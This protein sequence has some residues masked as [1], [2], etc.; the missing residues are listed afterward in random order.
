MT[1]DAVVVGG[2]ILGCSTAWHLAR[3]GVRVAVIEREGAVGQGSTAR[4]TAIIRQRY[5]HPA[6]MALALE[7]LRTWERWPELVPPDADG[8]RAALRQVGVLFLLPAGEPTTR[9]LQDA[10][11]GVGIKADLLDR[12]EL[13]AA[14]PALCIGD[15]ESVEGLFEPEGGVV[16]DPSR[17]TADVA[18]AAAAAGVAFHFGQ[19]LAEVTTRWRDGG[20]EVSGVRLRD[21]TTLEAPVVVNCA[22][23][24]SG[25]LNLV[26]RSPLALATAPL[27]QAVVDGRAPALAAAPGRLPVIADLVLGFYL[28]PDPDC[29]RIGAVWPQ[30][31]TEYLADPDAAHPVV[32]PALIASRVATAQRRVPGLSVDS[33]RGLV[34]VYDVTV[35]DWYPIVDRT[36]TRGYFV[37][38]GTSGA[39]F[40]AGP[41][42]GQLAAEMV[43]AHLG[44]GDADREP[45]E[46][47][48]PLTG[49]RFPMTLF[50]RR[51]PPVALSYG[52]GVL[53]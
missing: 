47:T 31:E 13:R 44:G 42:F 36:E 40:K 23:P 37:A 34:G 2:G 27:R 12:R 24:H 1:C 5:S 28:R 39:W 22:G 18:R 17:A 14:F 46:V 49:Y 53:G 35:Q 30:D 32:P 21:G 52:G 43:M 7:G 48:L 16:D 11:R 50:S 3:R 51:R 33:P 10:M 20:L 38:I 8:R 9:S 26:A 19:A 4:S 6:A 25:W 41:V 15:D 45:L 29:V